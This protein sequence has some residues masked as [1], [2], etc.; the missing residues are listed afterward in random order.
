MSYPDETTAAGAPKLPSPVWCSPKPTDSTSRNL[1]QEPCAKGLRAK[2]TSTPHLISASYL[3]PQ[4]FQSPSPHRHLSQLLP[5]LLITRSL[6]LSH[7]PSLAHA[8]CSPDSQPGPGSL[9][10]VK[11]VTATI[12][13]APKPSE[14]PSCPTAVVS[15]PNP[16]S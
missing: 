11:N 4:R 6:D 13:S 1:C 2:V 7:I 5:C 14:T 16:S 9:D 15:I 8:S 3:P 12:S 10:T